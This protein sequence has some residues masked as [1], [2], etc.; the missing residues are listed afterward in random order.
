LSIDLCSGVEPSFALGL[1]AQAPGRLG[2]MVVAISSTAS[3][4]W[5]PKPRKVKVAHNLILNGRLADR[6]IRYRLEER[7]LAELLL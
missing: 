3:V 6:E 7:D 1:W 2:S 5:G 4:R